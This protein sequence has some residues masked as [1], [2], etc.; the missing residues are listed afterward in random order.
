MK[1]INAF[2]MA[3]ICTLAASCSGSNAEL[4]S[5]LQLANLDTTTV[6]GNDF[7]QF[8][9]GG[10]IDAN[11][12]PSD[13][14][15]FGQ[16]DKLRDDNVQQINTL[17]TDLAASQH[18]QGTIPQKIGDLYNA[19]MDSSKLNAEGIEP[20]QEDI[21]L[22]NAIASKSEFYQLLAQLSKQ[23]TSAFFDFGLDTDLIN[24]EVYIFYFTQG[25][26]SMGE[27]E[28]YLDTDENSL[29]IREAF[30]THVVKMMQ[31]AGKDQA[32]SERIMQ[33]VMDVETRLATAFWNRTQLRDYPN[34]NNRY[35]PDSL[36]AAFPKLE[37][38]T[39]MNAFGAPTDCAEYI[40][41][42]P[43]ALAAAT[44]IIDQLSL[45]D[46]KL[47][48]LWKL[49]DCNA[50]YL[51]DDIYAQNFDFFSRT[52]RGTPEQQPRWKRAVQVVSGTLGEAVGQMYVEKYFSP[53]AKERMI[54]LVKNLQT[55][56]GERIMAAEWMSDSTKTKAMEKLNAFTVKIG[57]PDKWK[58]YS[59]L[60]IASDSYYANMKRAS[61]WNF[62]DMMSRYG[63]PV[64][65]TEWHMTPQTVNAYY[66]PS[67]NEI[68]FPAGIL[69]YPFFDMQA[70]D[71]YNYGA[72]G[73]VIGHEMTH[74]FDDNGRMFDKNGNMI[75]WWQ[76]E[77]AERFEARAQVLVNHF[78]NIEV[79]PGVKANGKLTLGE[80]IADLGGLLIAFQAFQNA[81]ASQPLA[82]KD[83]YTPSQRFFLSYANLWASNIRAEAAIEQTKSD[84]H[85]IGKWR[86]NGTLPHMPAWYEAFG[87]A[88]SDSL[89]IAPDMRASIW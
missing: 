41:G 40:V 66:S 61:L 57:Y 35:T 47:Y 83:G 60:A 1:T 22:I 54:A 11:P 16:F 63:K 3:A 80:N 10:W 76:A 49:I 64:D 6:P 15:R 34:W 7:N 70:D 45:D 78:D 27:K 17:I 50:V 59:S 84:P 25:G 23:G 46:Q 8:A 43:D 75:D 67:S 56:L 87:V 30:K 82:S 74:G 28:Y 31:L 51:S 89:Y 71:A 26:L 13:H 73:V 4:T 19:V 58:D 36:K 44:E 9:N 24:S 39:L 81:T 18:A 72:I 29:R 69:Q 68:C 77:D 62:A 42:Q 5:G 86:V 65:K 21:D 79:Q 37:F 32:T 33:I 12:L 38:E 53:A 55:A 85:S 20:L 2:T 48:L 14:A 88:E 52:M